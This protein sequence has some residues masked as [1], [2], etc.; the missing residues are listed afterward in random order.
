M[1][2]LFKSTNVV[3]LAVITPEVSAKTRLDQVV[4]EAGCVTSHSMLESVAAAIDLWQSS[5]FQ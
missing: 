5:L 2:L 3:L 1:F 4:S